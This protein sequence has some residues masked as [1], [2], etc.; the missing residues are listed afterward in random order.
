MKLKPR[1]WYSGKLHG[2]TASCHCA[3]TN[4]A[5]LL[6]HCHQAANLAITA[7]LLQPPPLPPPGYCRHRPALVLPATAA[8]LPMGCALCLFFFA[9]GT[10]GQNRFCFS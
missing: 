9:I 1:N 8:L 10:A 6:L 7:M 4:D 2:I 5:V 3:V